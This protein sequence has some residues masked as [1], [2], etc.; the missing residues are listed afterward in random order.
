[1][2]INS[3]F[4][5]VCDRVAPEMNGSITIQKFNRFSRLAELDLLDWLSGNLNGLPGYP[6]PYS[7]LK[8]RDYLTPVLVSKPLQ[9]ENGSVT[10]PDNYYLWDRAA[11]IGTRRDE[12]CGDDV[13]ISGVDTPIDLLDGATFDA[14][15]NTHIKS[16]QPSILKPICKQVGNEI[17]FLPKDLGSIILEY[18]KYPVYGELKMKIDPVYNTEVV[19]TDNSIN[20]EW[21]EYARKPLVFII[22]QYYG[23]GTREKAVQEQNNLIG[24]SATP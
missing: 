14:R 8:V 19:D 17:K 2:D 18:K 1:M 9:I 13:I 3:I 21:G 12:L 10:K 20:Y 11:I 6:E 24:K 22:T 4:L 15:A 5:D 7:T 23:A 16:L